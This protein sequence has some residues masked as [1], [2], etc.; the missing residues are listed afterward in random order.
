M[1][2]GK[3]R[4]RLTSAFLSTC[5]ATEKK[6]LL[7]MPVTTTRRPLYD[8]ANETATTWTRSL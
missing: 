6:L 7:Q 3:F 8:A 5:Y 4:Q 1:L 2:P